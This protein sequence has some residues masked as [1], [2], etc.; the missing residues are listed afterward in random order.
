VRALPPLTQLRAFE[1]AA[2]LLSFQG[3]AAE[4][5]VTPTA[6]SHQIQSLERYLGA[7]LFR[8]RPR[9]LALTDVGARLHPVI[10]E[11]LALL[12]EAVARARAD[13]GDGPLIVTT[14]N[15]FAARWLIPRLPDWRVSHPD[16][17]L[18]V[19]SSDA[20]ADLQTG[21]AHLAIRYARTPPAGL[22]LRKL[23]EDRHWAACKPGLLRTGSP[24]PRFVELRGKTPIH[25]QWSPDYKD[26]PT[27]SRFLAAA[28]ATG[29]SVPDVDEVTHLRFREEAHAIDAAVMGQGIALCSDVL[30]AT[31]LADGRL[32]K[33][34]DLSLPGYGF[35]IVHLPYR[36]QDKRIAAFIGWIMRMT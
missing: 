2:R 6:I 31:E 36:G 28:R 22:V 15:A 8:R 11:R 16:I 33:V 3:A 26:A 20:V 25:A 10:T 30:I 13:V 7:A 21:E 35:F 24:A 14:T 18:E 4:L 5:A 32:V 19:I 17:P 34:F 27:W 1:A 12:A 29:R 9:P 23:Y